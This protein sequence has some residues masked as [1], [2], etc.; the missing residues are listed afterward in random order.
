MYISRK[1]KYFNVYA[2]F[3]NS[4]FLNYEQKYV[5]VPLCIPFDISCIIFYSSYRIHLNKMS[6]RPEFYPVVSMQLKIDICISCTKLYYFYRN[7]SFAPI[8][9]PFRP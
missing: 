1:N 7:F 6:A 5:T 3:L 2:K 8:K 4:E 9:I